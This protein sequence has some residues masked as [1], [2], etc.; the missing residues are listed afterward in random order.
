MAE[1][2]TREQF[3]VALAQ[4]V[5]GVLNVYHEADAMLRELAMALGADEP[6]FSTLVKRL[7]PGANKKPDARFL[8]DYYAWVFSPDDSGEE[9]DE[10]EDEDDAEDEEDGGTKKANKPLTVPAGSGVVLARA[11][12]YDR[13]A[14]AFEPT[15]TIAVVRN[16]RTTVDVPTGTPLRIR[17]GNLSRVLRDID[18]HRWAAGKINTLKTAVPVQPV[19]MAKGKQTLVCDL[20][21]APQRIPLFEVMPATVHDIARTVRASWTATAAG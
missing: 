4:A 9:D 3:R 16:W 5:D 15:L 13:G 7:V 18:R 20:A 21:S 8:R 14:S 10:E 19:G 17:R 11:A 2:L 12:I 6:R 1:E